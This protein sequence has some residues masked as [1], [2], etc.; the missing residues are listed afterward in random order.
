M[1]SRFLRFMKKF[2]RIKRKVKKIKK[3]PEEAV[4]VSLVVLSLIFAGLC[5]G[6]LKNDIQKPLAV[7]RESSSAGLEKKI[8]VMAS[9]YP[10][11]RMAPYISKQDKKVAA[12]LIAIAKKESDWG[13]YSPKKRGKECFNYWGF[14]GMYNR[15]AAGYSCFDSPAQ[16]VSVVGRRL[17]NLIARRIDTSREMVM[18]KCGSACTARSSTDA[19]KWVSDVNLYY[20]KVL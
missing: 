9:D 17:E 8:K 12:Y 18:W 16:A 2:R 20:R 11:E 4:F 10:I 6:R 1:S 15:N 3:N 5:F 14:K 19:A 13:K 7:T